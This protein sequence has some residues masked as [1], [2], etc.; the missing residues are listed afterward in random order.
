MHGQAVATHDGDLWCFGGMQLGQLTELKI[1]NEVSWLQNCNPAQLAP[2]MSRVYQ[3]CSSELSQ[4]V[5]KV[6]FSS[7]AS[8]GLCCTARAVSPCL[9]AG[10]L[11]HSA[12]LYGARV[13]LFG[14]L[15]A[16]PAAT[17]AGGASS[18]QA[19]RTSNSLRAYAVNEAGTQGGLLP[20]LTDPLPQLGTIPSSRMFHSAAVDPDACKMY[21]FGGVHL[22]DRDG[23]RVPADNEPGLLHCYDFYSYTWTTLRTSDVPPMHTAPAAGRSKSSSKDERSQ[24]MYR[25]LRLDL[26]NNTWHEVPTQGRPPCPRSDACSVYHSNHVL[27]YGGRTTSSPSCMLSDLH[28]LDLDQQCPAWQQVQPRLLSSASTGGSSITAMTAGR[29]GSSLDGS[30][31]LSSTPSS[32]VLPLPL[33]GHAG[34]HLCAS[35]SGAASHSNFG[36]GSFVMFLGGY[37]RLDIKEPQPMVQ[38]L[39]VNV[40]PPTPEAAELS[41]AAVDPLAFALQH[42]RLQLARLVRQHHPNQVPPGI[43]RAVV[44]KGASGGGVRLPARLLALHSCLFDDMFQDMI[45]QQEEQD[46][47]D[48]QQQQEPQVSQQQSAKAATV[49]YCMHESGEVCVAYSFMVADQLIIERLML[50]VLEVLGRADLSLPHNA[51]AVLGFAGTSLTPGCH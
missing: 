43:D 39:Q 44:L 40:K 17:S 2:D 32:A 41:G 23:A 34:K 22:R 3:G 8:A 36:T 7:K 20:V 51:A 37:R 9:S 28:V 15:E 48:D 46:A 35:C 19:T 10:L 16:Q 4:Q 29:G 14:G 5:L 21:V 13:F 31:T 38:I 24:S 11:G 33:A 25:L 6:N 18:R 49:S 1:K 50:E 42:V 45:A 47:E 26:T 30:G 12:V 27:V